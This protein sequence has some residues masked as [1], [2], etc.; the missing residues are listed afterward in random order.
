M[1]VQPPGVGRFAEIVVGFAIV[2]TRFEEHHRHLRF[3]AAGEVEDGEG[4]HSA[5]Y[6]RAEPGCPEGARGQSSWR[7]FESG[8]GP[9]L[10]DGDDRALGYPAMVGGKRD[11]VHMVLIPGLRMVDIDELRLS[12]ILT[13]NE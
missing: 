2:E 4:V 12:T 3:D 9:L 8:E 13:D 6:W 11:Q 7:Q 10:A 5:G 1:Q